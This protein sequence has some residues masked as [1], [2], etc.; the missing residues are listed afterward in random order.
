MR[1][2]AQVL[3]PRQESEW[4]RRGQ[5]SSF[6]LKGPNSGCWGV[7]SLQFCLAGSLWP[8][9][10]DVLVSMGVNPCKGFLGI[11]AQMIPGRTRL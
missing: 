2:P 9:L 11:P 8:L 7:R 1:R 4:S 3:S 10:T 6:L 5:N